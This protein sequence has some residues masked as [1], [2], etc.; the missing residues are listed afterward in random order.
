MP[1]AGIELLTPEGWLLAALALVPLAGLVVAGRR[2]RAARLLLRFAAPPRR[3]RVPALIA[4]AAVPVLLAAAASQPVIRTQ[5]ARVVRADAEVFVVVDTSRSMRASAAPDAPNRFSQAR[6]AA[7]AVREALPGV[8]VGLASLTDRVLPHLFPTADEEAYA[9][10]LAQAVR[11]ELP[12]P[13]SSAVLA[14]DLGQLGNLGTQSFFTPRSRRRVAV[15]IT[16]GESRRLDT[17]KLRRSLAAGNVQLV[18]VRDWTPDDRVWDGRG[19][20][21][22]GYRPDAGAPAALAA[23][24]AAIGAPVVP[25]PD[26]AAAA[27]EVTRLLASGPTDRAGTREDVTRL[28]LWLALAA[29]IPLVFL[30]KMRR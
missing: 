21:E 14:T 28:G 13:G 29:L 2:E 27:R 10:T 9:R 5:H 24:G 19:I 20:P 6:A 3:S 7:G 1:L 18:L 23:L 17:D 16:D 11:I 4:A 8:R 15:V 26:G 30:W 22:P 25:G 12:P